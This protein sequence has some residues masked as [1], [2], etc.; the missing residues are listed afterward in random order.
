MN[1]DPGLWGPGLWKSL[2][3]ITVGY[4]DM[5]NDLQKKNAY[6]LFSSLQSMLPCEKCRYNYTQ[7]L[8]LNPLTDAILSSRTKLMNWF[9]DIH[10]DVNKSLGKPQIPRDKALQIYTTQGDTNHLWNIDIRILTILVTAVLLIIF[11]FISRLKNK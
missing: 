10:N 4:P 3:Y 6:N 9:I 7:H 1:V 2:H 5:A 11:L 8:K